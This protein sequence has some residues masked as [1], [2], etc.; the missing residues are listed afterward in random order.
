MT[1]AE[2]TVVRPDV[3]HNRALNWVRTRTRYDRKLEHFS[4]HP[5]LTLGTHEPDPQAQKLEWLYGVIR[6]LPPLDRTLVMLQLDGLAHREIA[7]VT[8]LS[9]TN[10]GVRLHRIKQ[11]LS[12][13]KPE[14]LHGL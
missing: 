9:E 5:H 6:G 7:E 12:N 10:V 11:T 1:A 8:G 3:A 4:Q 14:D 13:Q 2:P